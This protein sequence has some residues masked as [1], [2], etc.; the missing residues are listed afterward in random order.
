VPGKT[1]G[2]VLSI[3]IILISALAAF[4]DL[5]SRRIPNWLTFGAT[6]AAFT[7]LSVIRGLP[8]LGSSVLGAAIGILAFLP[9]FALSW[10]GAGDAKLLMALG[11]WGGANYAL[12]VA[13]LSIGVGAGLGLLQIIATGRLA[14]FV[15]RFWS[16][17]R[18]WTYRELEP[19]AFSADRRLTLPF[20]VPMAVAAVGRSLERL[21]EV[22]AWLR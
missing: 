1:D 9:L 22:I 5:R 17:L 20:A 3:A 2:G 21:P 15:R 16:F 19:M 14:D 13:F 18:S 8:G 10:I 12:N 4:W 6:A 7:Y 11:A